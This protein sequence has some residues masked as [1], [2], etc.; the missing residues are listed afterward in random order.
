[1][2]VCQSKCSAGGCGLYEK[3]W[4]KSKYANPRYLLAAGITAGTVA[5]L[6]RQEPVWPS[7]TLSAVHLMG[8]AFTS[9]TSVWVNFF[10]YPCNW[11]AKLL[12]KDTDD[13]ETFFSC[14][15]SFISISSFA[16][17]A[18]YTL[19]HPM[20]TWSETN[21]LVAGSLFAQLAS[22]LFSLTYVNQRVIHYVREFKDFEREENIDG[23]DENARQRRQELHD[24][25]AEYNS[26]DR[27][28]KAFV[29]CLA[30]SD[31]IL[32]GTAFYYGAKL[33]AKLRL[34]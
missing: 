32:I 17:V 21:A 18:T 13:V 9:G 14:Y 30:I 23:S 5:C 22:S 2:G 16:T 11:S 7:R 15:Y 20:N 3:Y 1:M 26:L 25:S 12:T 28:L 33:A 8:F 27:H 31:A 24:I 10:D 29:G 4:P 19:L 34:F 6:A